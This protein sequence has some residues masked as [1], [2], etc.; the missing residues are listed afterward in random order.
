MSRRPKTRDRLRQEAEALALLTP[1]RWARS[2]LRFGASLAPLAGTTLLRDRQSGQYHARASVGAVSGHARQQL[3]RRRLA[4]DFWSHAH[5][6]FLA[7]A[8]LLSLLEPRSGASL[9]GKLLDLGCGAGTQLRA[10]AAAGVHAWGIESSPLFAAFYDL[11]FQKLHRSPPVWDA[12]GA[13]IVGG[14]FSGH[15]AVL[16]AVGRAFDLVLAKNVLKPGCLRPGH[17]QEPQT[18]L[19]VQSGRFLR[20]VRQLLRPGG[21]FAVY[22]IYPSADNAA[23]WARTGPPFAR[24]TW[25]NAGFDIDVFEEDDSAAIREVALVLGWPGARRMSA[26]LTLATARR[27]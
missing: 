13:R 22:N 15:A 14:P 8:R 17:G 1:S 24:R 27:P 11:H 21:R 10:L 26:A 23:P 2:F 3:S 4:D 7:Y 20:A 5:G 25:L 12:G 16:G 18:V 19:G 6:S 9:P